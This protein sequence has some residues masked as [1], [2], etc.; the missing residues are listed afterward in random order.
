[1]MMIG[2]LWSTT[3]LFF[4]LVVNHHASHFVNGYT[5]PS[6]IITRRAIA[7]VWRL[8][9]SE[10]LNLNVGTSHQYPII[11][12]EFT[13]YPKKIPREYFLML[14]ED[15]SFTST[16]SKD[17]NE[18]ERPRQKKKRKAQT[19]NT[20]CGTWDYLDGKLILAADRPT[21][22]EKRRRSTHFDTM[23]VG[24]V[25]AKSQESLNKHPVLAQQQTEEKEET[26][27]SS[28]SSS[29][30]DTHLSVPMGNVQIGKFMYPKK[31]K[32]FFEQPNMLV[33]PKMMGSFELKQVL[34]T[35]NAASSVE[36]EG[37]YSLIEKFRK[38]DFADKKFLLSNYPIPEH[39]PKGELRWSI[40]YNKYVRDPPRHLSIKQREELA[41]Q[42]K[43]MANNISVMGVQLFANNTFVTTAGL[44]DSTVLRGK[45]WIV[46]DQRDHLQ[47]QVWRFGFGRSVSGSTYSEGRMLTNDDAKS[48]WGKINDMHE[49]DADDEEGSTTNK[50]KND[51]ALND[52][53]DHIPAKD[54]EQR[55]RRL[56]VKGSVILGVGLE[57]QPV[58]R[59]I[60]REEIEDN[61]ED[62][63][64]EDDDDEEEELKFKM[65]NEN[66][67]KIDLSDAFQ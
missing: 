49:N 11:M 20:V 29:P 39:Q 56:Q 34:G 30:V 6:E 62:E 63:E 45:W 51:P 48:Y 40:K 60:M 10:V 42:K 46:G 26:P 53:S 36:D 50:K 15:G 7:G 5:S 43:R 38:S 18:K 24:T 12:K 3:I 14:N 25:V 28:S 54:D 52:N 8:R 57:P 22:I 23:L 67:G 65:P 9:G 21:G 19:E 55:Q 16:G 33:Q 17:E 37:D 47:M 31:H 27:S 66:D 4:V 13:T 32:M 44:G 59:F 2:F 35:L 64:E 1:M 58:A 61:N 41:A